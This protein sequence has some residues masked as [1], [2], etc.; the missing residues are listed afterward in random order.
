[1]NEQERF[2][3]GQFGNDYSQR[4][5]G[6]VASNIEFFRR[7][8]KGVDIRSIIEFGAN[9]GENLQALRQLYPKAFLT[10]LEINEEAAKQLG[11]VADQVCYGSMLEFAVAET[12]QLAFTKG[13]LIHIAPDN[14]PKAYEV[15]YQSSDQYIL[16]AEYYNPTPTVIPYRGHLDRLWKRDFAGEMLDKYKDLRLIDYGFVYHRDQYPQDDLHWF[17]MEK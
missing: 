6:R 9:I 17:L 4:N 8:L 11:N 13:V 7:A 1:M 5:V 3:S 2:W 15:I 16:I 14:L 10:G 12:W